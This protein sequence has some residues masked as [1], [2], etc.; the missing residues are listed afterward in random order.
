MKKVDGFYLN[1]LMSTKNIK[2]QQVRNWRAC[3]NNFINDCKFITEVT[4]LSFSTPV[5]HKEHAKTTFV[6]LCVLLCVCLVCQTLM[7]N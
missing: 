3:C 2:T 5:K 6:H 4:N 7:A 1:L